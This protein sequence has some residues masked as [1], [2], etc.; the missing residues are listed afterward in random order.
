MPDVAPARPKRR[1]KLSKPEQHREHI[2]TGLDQGQSQRQIAL[3]L[4]IAPSSISE[5]L[6]TI[7]QE[8]QQIARFRTSRADALSQIQSKALK[9][10]AKIL[11]SL[12]DGHIDLLTP[13][14]KGN[15]LHALVVANGNA[16]DKERLET[17]QSTANISTISRMID[18]QVS[19]LYK[20][21]TT[22]H[23]DESIRSTA[24]THENPNDI[25]GPNV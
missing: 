25:N 1:T 24:E 21:S 18:G 12:S 22:P 7:D 14:Q 11:D 17:G 2:L 4:G 13:Q 20:R 3:S 8:K 5:W 15:L 23:I 10:Q 6:D 19:T 16:F 9:I